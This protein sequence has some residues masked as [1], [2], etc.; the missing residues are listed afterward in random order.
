M[1]N[2][3]VDRGLLHQ[4]FPDLDNLGFSVKTW[5]FP[6]GRKQEKKSNKNRLVNHSDVGGNLNQPQGP[7]NEQI[8]MAWMMISNQKR[9]GECLEITKH[10]VHLFKTYRCLGFQVIMMFFVL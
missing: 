5:V 4:Q 1:K 2:H 3:Q 7:L 6:A 9:H 8:V 10:P